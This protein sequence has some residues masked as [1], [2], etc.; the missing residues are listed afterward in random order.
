M[1]TSYVPPSVT[2][3]SSTVGLGVRQAAAA[4]LCQ[5]C[6]GVAFTVLASVPPSTEFSSCS[7]SKGSSASSA[8]ASSARA[9]TGAVAIAAAARADAPLTKL[10][11]DMS[12]VWISMIES[13]PNRLRHA[14]V[15]GR[16]AGRAG[17][18]AGV[19]WGPG[20]RAGIGGAGPENVR[21]ETATRR[22]E[23]RARRRGDPHALRTMSMMGRGPRLV[24]PIGFVIHAMTGTDDN[25]PRRYDGM[26]AGISRC[27][28]VE[29]VAER[30]PRADRRGS[31]RGG[32]RGGCARTAGER[33]TEPRGSRMA[34]NENQ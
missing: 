22:R 19:R 20:A 5:R 32:G 16:Q 34:V 14:V 4:S 23:S 18:L 12:C 26:R 2:S 24:Y 27:R 29:R 11:R 25:S 10:R 30:S 21:P 28:R 15:R 7:L 31:R 33:R 17:R 9:A 8:A 13:F 6:A 1:T 3:D